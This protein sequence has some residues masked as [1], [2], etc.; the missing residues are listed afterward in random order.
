MAL[1]LCFASTDKGSLARIRETPHLSSAQHETAL[2]CARPH[3]QD[4][5]ATMHE[6]WVVLKQV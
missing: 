2:E 4:A 5:N 3:L 6:V 1:W